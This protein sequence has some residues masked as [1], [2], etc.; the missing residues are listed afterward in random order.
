MW[1]NALIGICGQAI[2]MAQVVLIVPLPCA[3]LSEK[4]LIPD[5]G[6]ISHSVRK[7]AC[8]HNA[9]LPNPAPPSIGSQLYFSVHTLAFA[10]LIDTSR[11]SADS[12]ARG[13]LFLCSFSFWRHEEGKKEVWKYHLR[14]GGHTP[15][16]QLVIPTAF[17]SLS[18][19]KTFNKHIY[20]KGTKTIQPSQRFNK[21]QALMKRCCRNRQ[22]PALHR[23]YPLHLL[24][25]LRA[26]ASI[27]DALQVGVVQ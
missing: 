4:R 5:E 15:D 1:M 11:S 20:M 7:R 17:T 22:S 23:S 24:Q 2:R 13:L 3:T 9:T 8:L 25:R 14:G 16:F 18:Q 6:G 27:P 19:G 21:P 10:C 12:E 26:A